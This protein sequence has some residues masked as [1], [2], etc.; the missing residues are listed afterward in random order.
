VHK[1]PVPHLSLGEWL[2]RLA[3]QHPTEIDLGLDRVLTVA[4]ALGVL[5]G[6]PKTITVAGTNG[7]GSVVAL[8]TA[9]LKAMGQVV[10]TYASPHLLR[11]NERI[12]IDEAEADDAEIVAAFEHIEAVRGDVS[13]TYFESATLAALWLFRQRDVD[14]Q[15]LEVGLGGRLDAVNILDA[16]VSVITSIGLDHTDWLGPDRAAISLEKAGV[17]RQN[18]PCIVA[19]SDPPDA[20]LAALDDRGAETLLIGRDW[21]IGDTGLLT[22][23]GRSEP[24]PAASGLLASNIG[25]AIQALEVADCGEVTEAVLLQMEG[26]Q[27][28]GRLSQRIMNGVEYVFDVAHNTES[29]KALVHHLAQTNAPGATRA[30]FAVMGDKPIHD[31]ISAC[32][33]VFD[34]W[35]VIDLPQVPRAQSPAELIAVIGQDRVGD[36]GPLERVWET[37]K[38]RCTV[39]DRV[40]IFGSFLL[41]GDA[42]SIINNATQA[43][44]RA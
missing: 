15:V 23:K 38:G 18:R 35:N 1:T 29:V 33:G 32:E 37:L 9:G 22:A 3:S 10:G 7:K 30:V 19:E 12:S 26:V 43:G 13:L 44:E 5:R 14:V 39:G 36:T 40:V 28:L 4:E 41:V 34:E 42:F 25:A 17:A 11:F 31:M 2:D 21:R 6:A 20:L 8:L 27:L 16:D 24:L